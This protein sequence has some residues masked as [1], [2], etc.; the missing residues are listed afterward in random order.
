MEP[1]DTEEAP[2]RALFDA[3]ASGDRATAAQMLARS[4]ALARR[5]ARVGA[6][7]AEAAPHFLGGTSHYV[8]A[9]DTA[10]HIAAAVGALLVN[11][12][13][14]RLGNK[15]GSTAL[16]LAVQDTGRGGSGSPLA[17]E[18]QAQIIRLLLSHGASPSDRNL[19]GRPVRDCASSAW[20]QEL[21]KGA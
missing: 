6:S 3:I 4:P 5:P 13:Y 20:I 1:I 14:V 18:Q 9:G 21:L 8:Y 2:L 17:R 19:G 12:A 15:S 11:G 10:L 16:H 7:R